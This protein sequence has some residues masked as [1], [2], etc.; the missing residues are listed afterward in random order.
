MNSLHRGHFLRR[1]VTAHVPP[2]M[3]YTLLP[4]GDLEQARV[5]RLVPVPVQAHLG[6]GLIKRR[7]MDALG[8]GERAIDVED[9]G[10]QGRGLHRGLH[11]C[12]STVDASLM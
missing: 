4:T 1:H 6:K 11:G 12:S 5:K 9:Q 2:V 7:A 3:R 8:V 10:A